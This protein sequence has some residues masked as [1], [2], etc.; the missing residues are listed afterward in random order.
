MNKST[1]NTNSAAADQEFQNVLSTL[2]LATPSA[3]TVHA[4][5]N[6]EDQEHLVE[7]SD[8]TGRF[9]RYKK[10]LGVGAYK[11]V[12]KGFDTDEGV[13]IAWNELR[14]EHLQKK[15]L[16]K[17]M[18]EVRILQN[19]RHES[20]ITLFHSWTDGKQ[21]YFI[22]ELMTSGTL[23]T[24]IKKTKTIKPKIIKSWCRQI[25][26]GLNYLHTRSPP[27][28]HRDLKCDNVFI[29]GNNGQAKIGDLGLATVKDARY[30][31]SVLGTPEFMAPELY[32]ERYDEKVDVYAFGMCMIEMVTK[33]Y[34]YAECTNQAQIYKKVTSG[35]KPAALEKV[36]DPEV[37]EF[38]E[39][40]LQYDP[41]QRPSSGELLQHQFLKDSAA[42]AQV[43]EMLSPAL[44]VS[45]SANQ[46]PS[47]PAQS[48]LIS[49]PQQPAQSSN[50]GKQR[51]SW[52]IHSIINVE[53]LSVKMPVIELRMACIAPNSQSIDMAKD[54]TTASQSSRS[55]GQQSITYQKQEVKFP[56][57]VTVD[58]C[59]A[60]VSEMVKEGVL[61]ED[62]RD[63]ACL[64]MHQVVDPIIQNFVNHSNGGEFAISRPRSCSVGVVEKQLSRKLSVE[65]S[66]NANN[67]R[68]Q[69]DSQAVFS[70][71]QRMRS[72]S[73]PSATRARMDNFRK[74]QALQPILSPVKGDNEDSPTLDVADAGAND[75]NNALPPV[76]TPTNKNNSNYENTDAYKR[77]QAAD[78][79]DQ[80]RHSF[81]ATMSTSV[82]KKPPLNMQNSQPTLSE[83][84]KAMNKKTDEIIQGVYISKYRRAPSIASPSVLTPQ[85]SNEAPT[86]YQ[87]PYLPHLSQESNQQTIQ[88]YKNENLAQP[89]N[90]VKEST[91]QAHPVVKDPRQPV[92][93]HTLLV[94]N[95]IQSPVSLPQS[96]SEVQLSSKTG[97]SITKVPSTQLPDNAVQKIAALQQAALTQFD[98]EKNSLLQ[99]LSKSGSISDVDAHLN[100]SAMGGGMQ[101]PVDRS[102]SSVQRSRSNSRGHHRN[103]SIAIGSNEQMLAQ[104]QQDFDTPVP[105]S[106]HVMVKEAVEEFDGNQQERQDLQ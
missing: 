53:V 10:C 82:Q 73:S 21:V 37:K 75:N 25:L 13:E 86:A 50:V 85:S 95:D 58:T 49:R 71:T 81:L 99:P 51:K 30:V 67:S 77:R 35:V 69:Q 43:N 11:K 98:L 94:A 14:L 45:A 61:D 55:S 102:A 26:K 33:E 22:T 56:Y 24:Y 89:L 38:I 92:P 27:I 63:L 64:R 57:D 32:D 54:S 4:D 39:L 78:M 36:T 76:G 29:N 18:S 101:D 90:A 66:L 59:E 87:S 3:V 40:C 6:E 70:P 9:E 93:Q 41:Q 72:K 84:H 17:I 96:L 48:P 28:I 106:Q 7:A 60:V 47:I 42:A 19:L 79:A 52:L 103:I 23:K 88:A 1:A 91:S 5:D 74:L 31:S 68:M 104:L 44:T 97:S 46:S 20:I 2:H 12:F 16:D 65:T 100:L 34:P 62:D 105:S 83:Y 15:D 80:R 8:P